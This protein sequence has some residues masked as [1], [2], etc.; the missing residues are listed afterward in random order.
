[1]HNHTYTHTSGCSAIAHVPAGASPHIIWACWHC[2]S[3]SLK[4]HKKTGREAV[5]AFSQAFKR[6]QCLES[7]AA[8][9][10]G[11]DD[12]APGLQSHWHSPLRLRAKDELCHHI[13][14]VF[15]RCSKNRKKSGEI[16]KW[17]RA[18]LFVIT[19]LQGQFWRRKKH[20]ALPIS[21]KA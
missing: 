17:T 21:M 3:T 1:M 14:H 10:R 4:G 16:S 15:S 11:G 6:K 8:P 18:T 7:R 9:T 13:T 19:S 2:L 5:V 20:V 12:S